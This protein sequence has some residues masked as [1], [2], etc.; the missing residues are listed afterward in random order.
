MCGKEGVGL[1]SVCY[2]QVLFRR[3]TKR[4]RSCTIL[5]Q[6][7]DLMEICWA[8][9]ERCIVREALKYLQ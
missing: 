4:M 1:Y 9:T 5:V 2:V 3:R 8:S 7:S 6:C